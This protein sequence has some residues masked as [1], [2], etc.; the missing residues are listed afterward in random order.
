MRMISQCVIC[1]Q[2]SFRVWTCKGGGYTN[3]GILYLQVAHKAMNHGTFCSA[4]AHY[5]PYRLDNN[6]E[7]VNNSIKL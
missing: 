5:L 3:C 4:K 7:L 2:F 6:G 1:S